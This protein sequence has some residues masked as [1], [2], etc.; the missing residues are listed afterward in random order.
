MLSQPICCRQTNVPTSSQDTKA[1]L[2]EHT[3]LVSPN[4]VSAKQRNR[5]LKRFDLSYTVI[6]F[7]VTLKCLE[8]LR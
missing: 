1:R 6:S 2:G 3:G 7:E 4:T 5:V 8:E